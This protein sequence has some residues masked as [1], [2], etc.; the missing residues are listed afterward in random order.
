M[1]DG[2]AKL[3]DKLVDVRVRLRDVRVQKAAIDVRWNDLIK[4][5]AEILDAI[6]KESE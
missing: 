3:F 2:L 5:R 6:A 4:Q 1:N